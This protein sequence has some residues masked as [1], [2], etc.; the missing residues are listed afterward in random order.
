MADLVENFD[1]IK[2][3]MDDE[4]DLKELEQVA[5]V[6]DPEIVEE[7]LLERLLE[8][9]PDIDDDAGHEFLIKKGLV[10]FANGC[11]AGFEPL[12]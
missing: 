10:E 11:V 6:G 12:H 3:A 4:D 8:E 9:R 7:Y 5:S 1:L 2:W